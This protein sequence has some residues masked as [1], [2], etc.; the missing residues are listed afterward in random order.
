MLRNL[1]KHSPHRHHTATGFMTYS[2]VCARRNIKW[3]NFC[4]TPLKL[5]LFLKTSRAVHVFDTDN[6]LK[7]NLV[8]YLNTARTSSFKNSN[9]YMNNLINIQQ[10]KSFLLLF[11]SP[12]AFKTNLHSCPNSQVKKLW[13]LCQC[14]DVFKTKKSASC[15]INTPNPSLL[16]SFLHLSRISIINQCN[17]TNGM[18]LRAFL[19]LY[20]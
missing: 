4:Q 2:Q 10:I 14:K 6:S 20:F 19:Q 11:V 5:L 9:V 16:H 8:S 18:I 12:R 3:K 7:P 13:H 1:H 15:E 17:L